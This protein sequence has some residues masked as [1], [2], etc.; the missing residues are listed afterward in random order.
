MIDFVPPYTT[1][2]L[3]VEDANGSQVVHVG[4]SHREGAD[5]ETVARV[6]AAALN[7]QLRYSNRPMPER[8]VE[9][10][11]LES[12]VF[13]SIEDSARVLLAAHKPSPEQWRLIG[14]NIGKAL[15]EEAFG[16]VEKAR[17]KLEAMAPGDVEVFISRPVVLVVQKKA[18][19]HS[20]LTAGFP[21]GASRGSDPYS[22]LPSQG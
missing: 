18:E 1:R 7:F 21:A 12:K 20:A 2:G 8:D 17:A 4:G 13:I 16:I 11:P 14:D 19:S 10:G 22:S 15:H 9:V 5:G 6:I 3:I